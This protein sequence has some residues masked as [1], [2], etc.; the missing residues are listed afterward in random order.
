M[1][2]FQCQFLCPPSLSLENNTSSMVN[3]SNLPDRGKYLSLGA[4]SPRVEFCSLARSVNG[5]QLFP[6]GSVELHGSLKCKEDRGR[7]VP[8]YQTWT[9]AKIMKLLVSAPQ[10]FHKS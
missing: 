3:L 9:G 10:F 1:N 8:N 4:A 7:R 6:T 5:G 2:G